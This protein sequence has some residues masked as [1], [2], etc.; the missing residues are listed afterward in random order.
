MFSSCLF[1][2]VRMSVQAVTFE[3]DGI[4]TFLLS[5]VVDEYHI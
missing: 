2:S 1:L 3:A 4:E 5:T